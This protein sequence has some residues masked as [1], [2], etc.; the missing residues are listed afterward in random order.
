MWVA[1]PGASAVEIVRPAKASAI[2]LAKV[3]APAL[4]GEAQRRV[5]LA[6]ASGWLSGSPGTQSGREV[7]SR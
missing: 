2:S 1:G 6:K 4:A 7:R 5:A 3:C